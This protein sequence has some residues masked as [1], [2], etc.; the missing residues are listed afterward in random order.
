[1]ANVRFEIQ[2]YA[3]ELGVRTHAVNNDRA[4]VPFH[5]LMLQGTVAGG[6]ISV[7]MQFWL[8]IEQ[9]SPAG[10]TELGTYNITQ[11]RAVIKTAFID[12]LNTYE[13][14]RSEKPVYC[15]F[16]HADSGPP[17]STVIMSS[18]LSTQAEPLGEGPVDQS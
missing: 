17:N 11:R 9:L 6:P 18:A 12:L 7:V 1:M 15:A 10:P 2:S 4:I 14:V 8:G 5:Q 3:L 13:V 16:T